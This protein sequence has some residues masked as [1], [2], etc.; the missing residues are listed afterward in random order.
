MLPQCP[1]C[2]EHAVSVGEHIGSK[3]HDCPDCECRARYEV[4]RCCACGSERRGFEGFE[5]ALVAA[6]DASD[7]FFMKYGTTPQAWWRQKIAAE[8]SK[9]ERLK[10]G[11]W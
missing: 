1:A 4:L 6:R 11:R 9:I 8:T 5:N 7:E 3:E 10:Q 2:Q